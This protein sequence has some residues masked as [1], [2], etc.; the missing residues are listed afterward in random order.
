MAAGPLSVSVGASVEDR[1]STK[2]SAVPRT[3][4]LGFDLNFTYFA[5]GVAYI[6]NGRIAV[7]KVCRPITLYMIHAHRGKPA[8][9][10]GCDTWLSSQLRS[11]GVGVGLHRKVGT[12]TKTPMYFS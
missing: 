3:G 7:Q 5:R 10:C 12:T 9:F 8:G 4:V 11:E 2:L 6:W 1:S